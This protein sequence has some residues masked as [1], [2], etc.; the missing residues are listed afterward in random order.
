MQEE[1]RIRVDLV[2]SGDAER[3]AVLQRGDIQQDLTRLLVVDPSTRVELVAFELGDLM[4]ESVIYGTENQIAPLDLYDSGTVAENAAC[5]WEAALD[6]NRVHGAQGSPAREA[7]PGWARAMLERWDNRGACEMRS[8]ICGF[9]GAVEQ[10]FAVAQESG[11]GSPF[12]WEFCPW[13]ISNCLDWS[14]ESGPSLALDYLNRAR[15]IG[16]ADSDHGGAA[17]DAVDAARGLL[18]GQNY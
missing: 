15:A 12:D 9:A 11:F 4:V 1:L 2:F 14:G 16:K 13:F 8:D 17:I 6:V 5:L 3:T 18:T 7:A 10:A